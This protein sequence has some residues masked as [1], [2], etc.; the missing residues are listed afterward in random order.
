MYKFLLIYK[1]NSLN[2]LGQKIS[3]PLIL[4]HKFLFPML[5]SMAHLF[6]TAKCL[7]HPVNLNNHKT[8]KMQIFTLTGK[9]HCNVGIVLSSKLGT[10]GT[11]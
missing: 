1:K 8:L 3:Q 9:H 4:D 6:V 11:L 7:P 5:L 2:Y 10:C